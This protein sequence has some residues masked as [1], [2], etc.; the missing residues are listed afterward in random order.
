MSEVKS[1]CDRKFQRKQAPPV[2]G[3]TGSSYRS[4]EKPDNGCLPRHFWRRLFRHRHETVAGRRHRCPTDGICGAR[5]FVKDGVAAEYSAD[6]RRLLRL[7][8]L[9]P[10]LSERFHEML[11]QDPQAALR[12]LSLFDFYAPTCPS[13][14]PRVPTPFTVEGQSP[15]TIS[16]N[17]VL[18]KD[19]RHDRENKH[20]FQHA[21]SVF[22]CPPPPYEVMEQE[23]QSD[24]EVKTAGDAISEDDLNKRQSPP[25][26]PSCESP[27]L[28]FD[29]GSGTIPPHNSPT[30]KS[31]CGASNIDP[32]APASNA[33][34][35]P[36]EADYG[37]PL[38]A[39][40]CLGQQS[41]NLTLASF[42]RELCRLDNRCGHHTS[43][44]A[45]VSLPPDTSASPDTS[46]SLPCR[47][48]NSACIPPKRLR[49]VRAASQLP[50]PLSS[51]ALGRAYPSPTPTASPC[52]SSTSVSPEEIV[53]PVRGSLVVPE[54]PEPIAHRQLTESV[55]QAHKR[56]VGLL[57][58]A[59]C[60]LHNSSA[61]WEDALDEA[62]C[63]KPEYRD[64]LPS[65]S[66][67]NPTSF[68][69][70]YKSTN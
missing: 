70:K 3:M 8:R 61:K 13:T 2:R 42:G 25:N 46:M 18:D 19:E 63:P 5:R 15:V 45:N 37:A 51:E 60:V 24:A 26:V 6:A 34:V 65:H 62:G 17:F 32:D 31:I 53:I 14:P 35:S 48:C 36:P 40:S 69:F 54:L 23:W 7:Q 1:G 10:E 29:L 11:G 55:S 47:R 56:S 57:R 66:V 12:L 27:R 59:E 9:N 22:Q 38:T 28:L 52:L 43:K 20:Q 64:A 44:G 58:P 49:E 39:C 16:P 30:Q 67:M 21:F 33:S 4:P 41:P 68:Y 50:P